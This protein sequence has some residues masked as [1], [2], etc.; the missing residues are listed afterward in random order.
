M[1]NIHGQVL[2]VGGQGV[3]RA[4]ELAEPFGRG[5]MGAVYAASVRPDAPPGTP[6]RI[7]VRVLSSRF[8]QDS[9]FLSRFYADAT[10]ARRLQHPDL[11]RVLDVAEVGGRHCIA[12]EMAPGETLDKVL[13]RTGKLAEPALLAVGLAVAGALKTAW[14]QQR[15]LHHNLRPQ[16]IFMAS[17]NVVKLADIGLAR[18][19]ANE[20]G[21]PLAHTPVSDLHYTAPELA[22]GARAQDVQGDIYALG[23]TLYHLATG[24]QPFG[25]FTGPAILQRQREVGLPWA[26]GLNPV[27][28]QGFCSIL[29]KMLARDPHDRYPGYDAL[30]ADLKSVAAGGRPAEAVIR[31]GLSVMTRHKSSVVKIVQQGGRVIARRAGGEAAATPA[32]HAHQHPA[33]MTTPVVITAWVLV[34]LLAV[35]CLIA[36]VHR[37]DKQQQLDEEASSRQQQQQLEDATDS[38][39]RTRLAEADDYAR[40]FPTDT[41][42]IVERY[43]KV[44]EFFFATPAGRTAKEEAA[45]WRAKLPK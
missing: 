36:Y 37:V 43:E 2:G 35:A 20:A 9:A 31:E 7:A 3:L 16:N 23:A 33:W 19:A 39:A 21:R 17:G 29:E 12:M 18:A 15:L 34:F 6:P 38:A 32:A 8:H 11:V 27:L 28:S 30:L 4:M 22:L 42:G 1:S 44:A 10:A 13:A 40:R 26:K 5:S 24:V 45:K 41:A 14:M 25:R